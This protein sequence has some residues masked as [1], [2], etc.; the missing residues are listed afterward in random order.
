MEVS[1]VLSASAKEWVSFYDYGAIGDGVADD[2]AACQAMLN[3]GSNLVLFDGIFKISA[4]LVRSST[5]CI[6]VLGTAKITV[7]SGANPASA[8]K[9]DGD[10]V[11]IYR[12]G[13]EGTCTSEVVSVSGQ[14]P[15]IVDLRIDGQGGSKCGL[16]LNNPVGGV[17]ERPSVKNIVGPAT[18]YS[19]IGIY[20]YGNVDKLHIL[21]ADI[22]NIVAPV[23]GSMGDSAGASRAINVQ[24]TLSS[25]YLKIE[26]GRYDR[27]VGREGDSINVQSSSL[28]D[29]FLLIVDGAVCTDFNRRAIKAQ[30]G[31][32]RI[33]NLDAKI[34]SLGQSDIPAGYAPITTF[35]PKVSIADCDIDARYFD[36][37]IVVSGAT[38]GHIS[39]NTILVGVNRSSDPSWVGRSSQTGIY[40]RSSAK[41]SVVSNSITGGVYGVRF[42]TAS[43]C[44]ATGNDLYGQKDYGIVQEA[45]AP[46]AVISENRF[47]DEAG[48]APAY[49]IW[50]KG[51][52]GAAER[53]K[54]LLSNS[55]LV[56][57]AARA[58]STS[59]LLSIRGNMGASDAIPA[60]IDNGGTSNLF[61]GNISLGS[62]G[63]GRQ[64]GVFS[65]GNNDSAA[66]RGERYT[67]VYK[68]PITANRNV[69]AN[70]RFPSS[71]DVLRVIRAVGCTGDFS[72]NVADLKLLSAP[73]QWCEAT[74][75]G[76]AWELTASGVL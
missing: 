61:E 32:A 31:E 16:Y 20:A 50:M 52:G 23:T 6:V 57:Q 38:K 37:A 67:I 21:H 9:I 15:L 13:V 71:N 4:Q 14:R 8:L 36:F 47:Y 10:D 51:V 22:S 29:A 75:N 28:T 2:T 43:S 19:A 33:R 65:A 64:S 30:C 49:A 35:G 72:V 25:G 41:I 11:K 56:C 68:T 1:S 55:S 60:V 26:G 44:S 12:L 69:S 62:A 17:V 66:G 24:T 40:I 48:I 63:S 74:Y 7:A 53:N 59:S 70:S 58:E 5:I 18:V 73:G 46:V 45:D 3:S 39:N 76:S 54:V 27:I 34:Q 42:V